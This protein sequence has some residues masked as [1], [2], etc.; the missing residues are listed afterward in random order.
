MTS[1]DSIFSSLSK[2][3]ASR[4][5][6]FQD[7]PLLEKTLLEAPPLKE[8][9]L[10][11]EAPP[12]AKAPA[13]QGE[14]PSEGAGLGKRAKPSGGAEFSEEGASSDQE[15]FKERF[16]ERFRGAMIALCPGFP[17][18]RYLCAFSGGPD[19]LALLSLL[20]ETLPQGGL[21]AAHLDH[22]LRPGSAEEAEEAAMMADRL[23]VDCLVEA[24]DVARLA[25]ERGKGLE[26]AGRFARYDYLSRVLRGWGG[27]FIVTAHQADDQAET[28][29]LKLARGGGPGAL[30]GVPSVSGQVV[31][32]LLGFSKK[33]LLDYLKARRLDYIEDHSNLDRRF[34][35]NQVR[36][37]IL[38][39]LAE[40]NP[41][42]L[43]A[44][45]RAADLASAEEDF[46][47]SRLETLEAVLVS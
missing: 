5:A 30:A 1:S 9:P 33:E 43:A 6:S 21:L 14:G 15:S 39:H 27:D 45:G 3:P 37:D 38:P 44:L 34:R 26:E 23:G 20:R 31:R 47:R 7:A 19:S 36:R 4:A 46:W 28:I 22:G 16:R 13:G 10:L 40:L 2:I 24:K 11:K 41:A 25:R 35:R 8:S 17:E 12:S 29:I 18:G 32:P 42:Y